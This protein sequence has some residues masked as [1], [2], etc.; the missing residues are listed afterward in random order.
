MHTALL[1]V[2]LCLSAVSAGQPRACLLAPWAAEAASL[3]GVDPATLLAIA[4]RET[5]WKQL[6]NGLQ[7]GAW[8]VAHRWSGLTCAELHGQPGAMAAA[9]MLRRFDGDLERYAGCRR[10]CAWYVREV[11]ALAARLR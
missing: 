1:A 9:R 11:G 5:R 4:G 2:S 10:G 6:D 7:C 3:E 8:Q